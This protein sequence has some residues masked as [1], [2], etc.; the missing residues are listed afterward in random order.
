[1]LG[2]LDAASPAEAHRVLSLVG[3]GDS[4]QSF[5]RLLT[6][7]HADLVLNHALRVR[8][9]KVDLM[10][11]VTFSHPAT[12]AEERAVWVANF[13][14]TGRQRSLHGFLD[15]CTVMVERV[16]LG[17]AFQIVVIGGISGPICGVTALTV[18]LG[19]LPLAI[20]GAAKI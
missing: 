8:V 12:S 4:W 9:K 5:E 13:F 2:R 1:M 17:D 14:R 11:V 3:T 19:A 16:V 18:N 7:E 20:T 15:G 10:L 6:I